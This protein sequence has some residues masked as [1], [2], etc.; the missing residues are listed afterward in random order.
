M[1]SL[2][3]Y[4]FVFGI[5]QLFCVGVYLDIGGD[6]VEWLT[7]W[8]NDLRIASHMGS[9]PVRDKWLFP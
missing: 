6:V 7:H 1:I 5:P 4:S 2:I 3:L 9:N 8:T